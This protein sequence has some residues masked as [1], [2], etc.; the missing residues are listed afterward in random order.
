MNHWKGMVDFS[1]FKGKNLGYTMDSV[2]N[3]TK[4]HNVICTN[5]LARRLEGT[6]GYEGLGQ[7]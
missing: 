3:H 4:L 7:Y 2:Y 1:H 5:E 6:G